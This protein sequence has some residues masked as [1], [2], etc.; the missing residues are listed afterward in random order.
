MRNYRQQI[1]AYLEDRDAFGSRTYFNDDKGWE[2]D[3]SGMPRFQERPATLYQRLRQS[4]LAI[5]VLL[6]YSVGLFAL[7]NRLFARYNAA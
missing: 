7:S 4:L 3:L 2:A 5:A 1:I 6:V